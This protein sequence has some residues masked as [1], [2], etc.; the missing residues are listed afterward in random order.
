MRTAKTIGARIG[1]IGN[2]SDGFHGKTIACMIENFAAKVWIEESEVLQIAPH[3]RLDPFSFS[4][5]QQLVTNV[6]REGYYGGARLLLASAKRFWEA[7][8]AYDIAL[9]NR[10]F[11]IGY[12]TT[13][14]RRV[15]LAGSSAIVCGALRALMEF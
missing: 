10:N 11:I 14:P 9:D 12:S 5:L 15:G 13:I 4:S 6:E 2:P 7:C 3:P 8:Q 1:V